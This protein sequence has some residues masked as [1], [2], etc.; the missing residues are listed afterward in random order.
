MTIPVIHLHQGDLPKD[1][2]FNDDIAVD[3]EMTGLGLLR[4]RLCLVQLRG[5]GGDV[6]LVKIAKNQKDAPH[7]KAALETSAIKILQY[8][9][10]DMA[11]LRKDLDIAMQPVYCTKIASK[12]VRTYTEKHGL[13]NLLKE[14]L[15]VDANKEEQTTDWAADVL[16]EGQL[17]YA[18]SDVLYLHDLKA[19]LVA[20]LARE[21]RTGLAQGCFDFLPTR[22][23]LDV[24]GFEHEDMFAHGVTPLTSFK[25]F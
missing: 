17:A 23:L 2:T 13:K 22:A 3:C 4:D 10:I 25:S 1:I 19:K 24:Q 5:E 14:Y 7:L 8:A 16:T 12:L 9:R 15:G 18:A 21:G 11:F 20:H 6:H